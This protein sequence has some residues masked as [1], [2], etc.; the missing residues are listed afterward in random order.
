MNNVVANFP[1]ILEFAQAYGLPATKKRAILKEY[2]QVKILNLLYQQKLSARLSFVGGT[3]LRLLYGLDRFSEDLDFDNLGLKTSQVNGLVKKIEEQ[4]KKEN[5]NVGL[6]KNIKSYKHYY[7]FRF[8]DLLYL[9]KISSNPKEKLMIKFD[10]AD[11]WRGQT[12][13]AALLNR[14]GFTFSVVVNDLNQMLIQKLR[15]YCSRK[16]TQPRDIYDIVWLKSQGGQ[17]DKRFLKKNNLPLDL[18]QI[19][20]KKFNQE[21]SKLVTYKRRLRPFL[22]N[23]ENVDKLEHLDKIF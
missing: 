23:E 22:I 18:I 2:L 6:Y 4:L 15:A 10:Y 16:Q 9:L 3:C 17:L 7:E 14:Y 19:V 21:K 1:Q 12:T 8:K 20:V 11:F 13:K 5:I